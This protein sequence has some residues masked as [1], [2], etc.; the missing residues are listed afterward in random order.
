M[1][2][3]VIRRFVYDPEART[4]T[5]EFTSGDVYRYQEVPPDLPERWRAAYSKGRFFAA[6]VRDRF[7][8]RRVEAS[9]QPPS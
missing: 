7:P 5:V 1:P 3:T 4:L 9:E 8:C 6:E 2:S